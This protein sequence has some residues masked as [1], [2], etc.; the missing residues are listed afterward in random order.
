MKIMHVSLSVDEIPRS[1]AFYT[2]LFGQEPTFEREGYCKWM[3]DDPRVNFSLVQ[4][5]CQPGVD[6]IGIQ[7]ESE[8]A[9]ED[10]R[11]R[12]NDAKLVAADQN[13]LTCG[14]QVQS[15]TWVYDPHGLPIEHFFTHGVSDTFGEFTEDAE[16]RVRAR[17]A[18]MKS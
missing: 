17:E 8:E 1:K 4:Q 16:N 11:N 18:S 14:F 13:H 10:A 7:V 6:H 2:R 15:K 9:L 3:L 12:I 5:N